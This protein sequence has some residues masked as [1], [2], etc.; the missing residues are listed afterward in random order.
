M[1]YVNPFIRAK[2]DS[3]SVELKKEIWSQNA[4]LHCTG[5]LVNALQDVI[6]K[7]ESSDAGEQNSF[8]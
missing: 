5:D 6:D 4:S 1:T 2:F 3:L 8:T 7:A